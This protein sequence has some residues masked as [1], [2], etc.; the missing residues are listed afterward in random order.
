MICENTAVK[1]AKVVISTLTSERASLTY[2][3]ATSR[4]F[5]LAVSDASTCWFQIGVEIIRRVI[6]QRVQT[7][8]ARKHF[9]L[10]AV[11]VRLI[12]RLVD[13]VRGADGDGKHICRRRLTQ[14]IC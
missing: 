1:L 6:H 12:S 5:E 2:Q 9:D 10:D 11:K 13:A 7:R 4:P 14:L 8:R 3:P